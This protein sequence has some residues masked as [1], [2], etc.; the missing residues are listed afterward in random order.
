MK[1]ISHLSVL[2]FLIILG[3]IVA[4]WGFDSR[5]AK[6]S[7]DWLAVLAGIFLMIEAGYRIMSTSDPVFP[8][9]MFRGMRGLIGASIFTI[10]LIQLLRY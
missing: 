6:M 5:L 8:L 10:H 7:V 9:Q 4:W 2:L 1:K 3:F